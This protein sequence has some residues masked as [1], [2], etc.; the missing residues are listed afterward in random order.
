MNSNSDNFHDTLWC[1]DSN[2]LL[3]IAILKS[4]NYEE[5]K[6]RTKLSAFKYN[7]DGRSI[8]KLQIPKKILPFHFQSM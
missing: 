2:Q 5:D 6:L 4:Y 7:H 1:V 8:A 3:Y